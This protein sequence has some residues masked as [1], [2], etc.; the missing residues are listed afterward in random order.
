MRGDRLVLYFA[1]EGYRTW[2][3]LRVIVDGLPRQGSHFGE[4]LAQDD[5][6]AADVIAVRGDELG[7]L[8]RRAWQPPVSEWSLDRELLAALFDRIGELAAKVHNQTAKHAIRAPKRYPRPVTAADRAQ[9]RA[10][11]AYTESLDAD[12]TAAVARYEAA[13]GKEAAG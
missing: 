7:R 3:Q 2:R 8:P 4:A 11:I 10:L 1:G 13:R 9:Q 5:E 6:L 12:Y